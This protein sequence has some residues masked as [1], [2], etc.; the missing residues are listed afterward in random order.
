MILW[1]TT[2]AVK[3]GT[4]SEDLFWLS[5]QYCHSGDGKYFQEGN[6]SGLK[7]LMCKIEKLQGDL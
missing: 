4:G 6:T 7:V 2:D 5:A 3:A 1:K